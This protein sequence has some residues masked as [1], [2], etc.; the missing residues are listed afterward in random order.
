MAKS[1]KT[2][3]NEFIEEVDAKRLELGYAADWAGQEECYFRGHSSESY[4][5]SPSLYRDA[6]KI[7][8]RKKKRDDY[9]WQLEYD[10]YYE[11]QARAREL[12]GLNVTS[13][14]ILFWMQHYGLPTRVLDWS[15]VFSVALFFALEK[16]DPK[17]SKTPCIW[18][19]NP[20]ALN[21]EASEDRDLF[22][23]KYLGYDGDEDE[24][25]GYDEILL[26]DGLMELDHPCAV[27]P[28]LKNNRIHAQRGSFTVH[29]DLYEPLEEQFPPEKFRI[30]RK[31]PIPSEAIGD[32]QRFLRQSGI[33]RHLLFPDLDGLAVALN[34][35]YDIGR[36]PPVSGPG[37]PHRA[38]R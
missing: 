28:E 31:V 4:L 5:L 12:H 20:Y 17:S 24:F 38:K 35:K 16:Y 32:A 9:F 14:D 2:A 26:Y 33:D 19:L 21:E 1:R 36:A 10:L 23:P 11:F 18:M 15:E 3:W 30:L 27:Y 6:K 22:S 25:W 7:G 8:L 13:W 29:G 34:R 37:Q